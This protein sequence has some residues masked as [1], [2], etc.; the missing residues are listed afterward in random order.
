MSLPNALLRCIGIASIL[1]AAFGLLYNAM[2]ILPE[3][4]LGFE[5][6][7]D[8]YFYPA[9]YTMSAICVACYVLLLTL[10]IQFVRLNVGNLGLFVFLFLFEI[11]YIKVVFILWSQPTIGMSVA[12]ATGVA[13]GGLV[14]QGWTLFPI[15]AVPTLLW[16]RHK[17]TT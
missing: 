5:K 16:A 6:Q 9:F 13:N 8:P 10:G 17:L 15:W 1:L 4:F 14:P 12:E 7:A 2:F 11:I 3:F